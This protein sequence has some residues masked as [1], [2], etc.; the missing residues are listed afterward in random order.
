VD[1][2]NQLEQEQEYIVNRLGQELDKLKSEKEAL[3][4]EVEREEGAWPFR[5]RPML[6]ARR[7][8]VASSRSLVSPLAE[9]LTNTLQKKLDRVRKEKEDL[10]AKL[11][12]DEQHIIPHLQTQVEP[13]ES[14]D[15]CDARWW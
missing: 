6:I 14:Q 15:C 4:M 11:L 8:A 7:V 5:C 12:Y 1:L 9:L 3:A 10:E 2:E 13:S